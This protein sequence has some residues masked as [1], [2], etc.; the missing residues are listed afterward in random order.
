MSPTPSAA[1][2][3]EGVT[4]TFPG[5]AAPAVDSLDLSIDAGELLVLLG[6]SGCGKTTTLR[7]IN[8][9]EE[10]TAGR[11]EV[12]GVDIGAKPVAE[13]RAGFVASELLKCGF[14]QSIR[15]SILGLGVLD[16]AGDKNLEIIANA[17][18]LNPV[19][20]TATTGG[21]LLSP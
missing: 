6:P 14:Q 11:I 5:A 15:R 19:N 20:L 10:P 17:L 18:S 4:K 12:G 13:R 9:L 16:A 7:M 2:T 1:I 21:I 3:L 8:R